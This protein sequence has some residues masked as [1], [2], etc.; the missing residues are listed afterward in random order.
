MT[1]LE[2][3]NRADAPAENLGKPRGSEPGPG[4]AHNPKGF[5][6][7]LMGEI[8]HPFCQETMRVNEEGE[9][10]ACGKKPRYVRTLWSGGTIF[11]CGRH[12]NMMEDL[13]RPLVAMGSRGAAVVETNP[14]G[15]PELPVGTGSGGS[16]R[17]PRPH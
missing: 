11:S 17:A 8:I 1:E 10:I 4:W 3:T 7:H 13:A 12:L 2:T 16:R 9:P 6:I 5:V 14:P 15:C